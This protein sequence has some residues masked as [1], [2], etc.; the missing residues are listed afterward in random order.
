MQAEFLNETLHQPRTR[1]RVRG[2]R[3]ISLRSVAPYVTLLLVLGLW[4]LVVSLEL[5]PTFIIPPPLAVLEKFREV[6]VDGRLWLH[7]S[8]TLTQ[9][10]AGLGFGV[11]TG[12]ALGY[13]IAKNRTLEAL[14]S[15][16]IVA[17]QATPVVAYAPLLILWFG[18]G[19]TSKVITSA[20]I[21]FF[22]M[23]MNTVVG[24]RT[25]PAPLRELMRSL[26]ATPWQMFTRLEVPAALPVLLSGLKVS[27]T[28]AVIGAVVGEFVSANAGL[29]FLINVARSQFDTALVFV[30]MITL[31]AIA[32]ALYG[33]VGLIERRALAWHT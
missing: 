33:V 19:M 12:V 8:T 27:A 9:T 2:L 30:V 25:V 15:P 4:Q 6:L 3:R 13:L 10:L 21:V 28:L 16:I 31:A 24:V 18:S 23:L 29:G 14:L 5:Y 26:R 7:A 17:F 32:R 20:L 1:Q 11:T 22:P